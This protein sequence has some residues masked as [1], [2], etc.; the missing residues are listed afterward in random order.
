M[1]RSAAAGARSSAYRPSPFTART[2][3]SPSG[4]AGEQGAG[5]RGPLQHADPRAAAEDLRILRAAADPDRGRDRRRAGRR[6][7][8]GR[9]RRPR[10][11]TRRAGPLPRPPSRPGRA[12]QA[13]HAGDREQGGQRE[14][15]PGRAHPLAPGQ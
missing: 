2:T 5:D 12:A 11:R 14:R 3:T 10:R 15:A 7:R 4:R 6:W 9:R 13:R 1:N 8:P